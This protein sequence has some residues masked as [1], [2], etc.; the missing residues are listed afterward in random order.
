SSYLFFVC[1]VWFLFTQ[2]IAVHA[3]VDGQER[4][5]LPINQTELNEVYSSSFNL[6]SAREQTLAQ[7]IAE[8]QRSLQN[9]PKKLERYNSR[10]APWVDALLPED[11]IYLLDNPNFSLPVLIAGDGEK[12][13]TIRMMV[14]LVNY[15]REEQELGFSFL[16]DIHE[17]AF[18]FAWTAA[19]T[20]PRDSLEATW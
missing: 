11:T 15:S 14:P 20:W 8:K 2:S 1:G 13:H 19:R 10:M 9:Q 3:D 4:S 18:G 6:T 17:K 12:I 16:S 7:V 5:W